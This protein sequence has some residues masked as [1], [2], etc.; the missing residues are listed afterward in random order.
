M[1]YLHIYHD[2]R[3]W[4]PTPHN[5]HAEGIG[6]RRMRQC[7]GEATTAGHIASGGWRS[8]DIGR[9]VP[10]CRQH[11]QARNAVDDGRDALR[12]ILGMGEYASCES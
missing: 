1:A 10:L 9:V 3:D 2:H 12:R 8:E 6:D 4:P 11:V 7:F 5:C